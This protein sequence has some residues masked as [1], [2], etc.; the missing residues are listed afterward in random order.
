MVLYHWSM[1]T[2]QPGDHPST[3]F[4]ATALELGVVEECVQG[5]KARKEAGTGGWVQ[6]HLTENLGFSFVESLSYVETFDLNSFE[7]VGE[8]SL[9]RNLQPGAHGSP[10]VIP[11]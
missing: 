7:S 1:E 5:P 10:Q 4:A 2:D 9:H 11:R 3:R 6:E 8:W